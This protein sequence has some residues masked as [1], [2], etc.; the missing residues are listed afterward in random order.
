MEPTLSDPSVQQQWGM[1]VGIP[2][3]GQLNALETLNI[4][5]ERSVTCKG[6]FDRAPSA[7]PLP[8][9]APKE[10]EAFRQ[11]PDA[12][13]ARRRARQAVRAQPRPGQAAD[14]LRRVLVQ[15]LVRRQGHA[16]HRRQRRQL[17]H[18]RAEGRFAGHRR[19]A[20]QGRHHLR[21]RDRRQRRRGLVARGTGEAEDEHAVRPAEVRAVGRPAVQSLRHAARAARHQRR[22]G[23]VGRRQPGDLLDLRAGLGLVQGPGVAQRRRQPA[24]HEGHH[25]GRRDRQQEPGRPRRHPL[26]DGARRR[27]GARR[28]QG[29]RKG[30]HL[31]G[32]PQGS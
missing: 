27:G 5:G 13:R 21:R 9:G 28:D 8:A 4:R 18:G 12:A 17:R 16:R 11:L 29:L 22:V 10:C 2:N 31:H 30:R 19:A 24:D 25:H 3:A 1:R 15:E 23:R 20:R 26:Q 6:D 32:D 14:V 7:G